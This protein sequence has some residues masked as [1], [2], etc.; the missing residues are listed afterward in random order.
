MAEPSGRSRSI[1]GKVAIV[2]GAASGMGR[3]T[4]ELFAAE[5]A[6]V[7]LLDRDAARLSEVADAIAASGGE[8]LPVAIDL[9]DLASIPSVVQQVRDALGPVDIVVNNAGIPSGT[10]FD[11]DDFDDVWRRTFTINLDAQVAMI[12]ACLAD[13]LRDGSGRIVNIA[14][15]EALGA[16]P[17]TAPYT[18]S[19]TAVIGLTRSLAVE[20]GRRGVTANCVCPGPIRTAMTA[21]IPDEAKETFARRRVPVGRYGEPE[22]VAHVILSLVLP[23]SSY[24]NGAVI[25]VDGGMTASSR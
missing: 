14:S 16:T 19:K 3:A 24:L 17:R 20:L 9:G 22:E 13:L 1:A 2:T 6:R 21:A 4:A 12:R 8:A 18:A 23:A 15:T 7:A 11:A 25:P 10:T 5:G